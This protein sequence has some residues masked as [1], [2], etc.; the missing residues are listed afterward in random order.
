MNF[1]KLVWNNLLYILV[2][3]SLPILSMAWMAHSLGS[4]AYGE[5]SWIENLSRFFALFFS[6]GIPLYGHK[7][8]Q[9]CENEN[10]R[11]TVL[12]TILRFHIGIVLLVSAGLGVFYFQSGQ[13]WFFPWPFIY[14][15]SQVFQLEWYFQGIKRYGFLI[16]RSLLIRTVA[17]ILVI[18]SIKSPDDV[19]L[20]F[21]IIC[22]TQLTIGLSNI[23][24]L[25]HDINFNKLFQINNKLHIDKSLM[26]LSLSSIVITTYSLLDTII[27]KWFC[28]VQFL[29][30]YFL[31]LRIAK[32]PILVLGAIVPISLMQLVANHQQNS[33]KDYS[34]NLEI[35]FKSMIIVA[36][37]IIFFVFENAEQI[38][39]MMGGNSFSSGSFFL[40]LLIWILPMMIISNVFG[41]QLLVS[42]DRERDFLRV[43]L[44]GLV[45]ALVSYAILIPNFGASGVVY[46]VLT[47]EFGVAFASLLFARTVVNINNYIAYLLRWVFIFIPIIYFIHE[48]NCLISNVVSR[49]CIDFLLM[50]FY[51]LVC[52]KYVFKDLW[53]FDWFKIKKVDGC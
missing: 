24:Y 3:F 22:L 19:L 35:S 5:L 8:V 11:S 45:V 29:G 13:N 33:I 37:P 43:S 46:A 38:V 28:D 30:S 12:L 2:Q 53:F 26:Y 31:S 51:L 48:L 52:V 15:I 32:M 41:Y 7:A 36:I 27:L 34:K 21:S 23:F 40:K 4:Y 50:V 1:Q 47:T 49:L 42:M 17:L 39:F 10:E 16:K 18:I 44:L 25:R 9:R 14:L 6:F 20:G